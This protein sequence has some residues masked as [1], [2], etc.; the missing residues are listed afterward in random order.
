MELFEAIDNRKTIRKYGEYLPTTDEVKRIIN[1]AR[2]APSAM[3][4]QNWKFIAIFNQ[5]V[6]NKL[7]DCVLSSYARILAGLN[8][9]LNAQDE[10]FKG[11]ST[12][13]IT[14]PFIIVCIEKEAPAFMGG[15]LENAGIP[16]E[17]I[18]LMRPD[19]YLLSMG[20]AIEN[21]LLAGYALGLGS[22]WMVAPVLGEKGMREVLKL[23]KKD[24]I[25][26]ILAFGRPAEDISDKRSPKKNLEEIMEIIK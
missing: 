18:K 26:S 3:N 16:D 11:H 4:V 20:G 25:V 8:D 19:S 7:A 9:E 12:Y 21:M 23:D 17:E 10:R 15:A 14:A 5:D 24:K 1:S 6:K 13:F 22:C 2:L